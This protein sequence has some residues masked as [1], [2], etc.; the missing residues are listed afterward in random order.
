MKLTDNE[1]QGLADAIA[2]WCDFQ[3]HCGRGTL[4]SERYL[5]QP[6]AE[7]LGSRFGS[8]PIHAEW[9]IGNQR[10]AAGRP[11]QLDFAVKSPRRK[12]P[13]MAIETKW[14]NNF[15]QRQKRGAVMDI[16]RLVSFPWEN[17][18]RL[19]YQPQRLFILA[20]VPDAMKQ[21]RGSQINIGNGTRGPFLSAV[22]SRQLGQ[23]ERI[24]ISSLS[25]RLIAMFNTFRTD[26]GLGLPVSY[27]AKLVGRR[28]LK[29][30][31]VM[32]WEV[33]RV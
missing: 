2:A 26:Y 4:L 20:G 12:R 29:T 23:E 18:Q 6:I 13:T 3:V 9:S 1:I 10:L 21:A 17:G 15:D 19:N 8:L 31:Q 32:I 22:L 16:M 25:E 33:G 7:F 5:V 30:V 24:K 14:V 27:R 28:S 11:R